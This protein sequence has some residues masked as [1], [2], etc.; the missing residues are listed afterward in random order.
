[1][2]SCFSFYSILEATLKA[3]S[4]AR[5]GRQD[6]LAASITLEQ[7]KTLPDARGDV[8]RGLGALLPAAATR[9]AQMLSLDLQ[10]CKWARCQCARGS[11]TLLPVC[12]SP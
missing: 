1:M 2:H 3:E 9:P 11:A 4:G 12:E 6:E 10:A 7:G 5:L 8:F